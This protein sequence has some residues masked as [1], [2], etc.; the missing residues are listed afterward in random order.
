MP[1]LY[2]RKLGSRRYRDYTAEKLEAAI[3]DVRNGISYRQAG[4]AHGIPFRTLKNKIDKKH[5]KR[6]GGQ[7]IF[8]EEEELQL[9]KSLKVCAEWGQPI[10]TL[11]IR[12]I[13][14]RM[15]S[16]QG[17]VIKQFP[18]NIPGCD[19]VA[20]FISRHKADIRLRS[21][22]NI[23]RSRAEKTKCEMTNYFDNLKLS[24]K[25]IPNTCIINYDETNLG[26]DPGKKKFIFKR[27]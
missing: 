4:E 10:T 3:E 26:D 9:V 13:A 1:R 18:N 2:K 11:E 14:K 16:L 12:M 19:W 17:R 22:A 8:S 21:A 24:L 27:G 5:T 25:D 6:A 7:T 20:S 23:K 15:L